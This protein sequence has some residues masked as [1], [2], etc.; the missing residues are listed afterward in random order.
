MRPTPRN[1]YA[2]QTGVFCGDE[3]PNSMQTL[4]HR[5]ILWAKSRRRRLHLHDR[6]RNAPAAVSAAAHLRRSTAACP[7][8]ACRMP[9]P[10]GGWTRT[11]RHPFRRPLLGYD[12]GVAG[13]LMPQYEQTLDRLIAYMKYSGQNL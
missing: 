10:V 5:S 9:P 1:D 11:R 6:A 3:Y 8:A 12:F 4:T 7:M 2:L 13:Q